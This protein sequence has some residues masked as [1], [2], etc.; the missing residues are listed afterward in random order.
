MKTADFKQWTLTKLDKAFGLNQI[1]VSECKVLQG[2]QARAEAMEFSEFEKQIL[3][4][5]QAPLIWAGKAWNAT[6]LENKFISP[7]IMAAK[8]DDRKIGYFLE[9]PL[10]GTVGDYTLSGVV[11]GMIATGLRDPEIPYFCMH[12]YKRNVDNEG[13]P[14]AQALAAM[15]AAREQNENQKA[16]YGLY[17]I[18]TI[19]NFIVLNIDNSYCV[20]QDYTASDKGVFGIFSMVKAVKAII[21]EEIIGH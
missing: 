7:L 9:R 4:D 15:L 21:Q 16:V 3:L 10:S 2:W 19:W 12:E 18:G 14:D 8:I 11:D 13:N 17:I 20:S 5:L 6:E 1:L